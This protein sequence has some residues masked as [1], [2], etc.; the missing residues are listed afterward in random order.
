MKEKFKK[1]L[2]EMIPKLDSQINEL[3]EESQ[4]PKFLEGQNMEKIEEML[5]D[6]AEIE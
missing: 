6:L 3:F 1:D 4:H 2:S 5:I